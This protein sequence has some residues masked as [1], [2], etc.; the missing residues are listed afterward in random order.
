MGTVP[1]VRRGPRYV[2]R[3][4]AAAV[5]AVLATMDAVAAAE[6]TLASAAFADDAMLPVKYAGAQCRSGLAGGNVSPPFAW[7]N[8]PPQTR[9]FALI[10]A[11]ADGRRGLGSVH[12]VA[13]GIPATRTELKEGAGAAPSGDAV[14]QGTDSRIVQGKNTR[15]TL[16]YS[17]PCGGAAADAAHHYMIELIALDLEPGALQG[18]LD[19]EQLMRAI[20]GHALQPTSLVVRYKP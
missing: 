15:G 8:P 18:G 14:V 4:V 20:D 6:F 10:F 17:G 19:R 2:R 9:S 13:Y 11:D 12:W 3:G 1:V 16:G 5:V 7:T